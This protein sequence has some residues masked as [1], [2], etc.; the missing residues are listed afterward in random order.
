MGYRQEAAKHTKVVEGKRL[1][2]AMDKRLRARCGGEMK[3]TMNAIGTV[4]Y[5]MLGAPLM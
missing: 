2:A 1:R 5:Y 3:H 4:Q